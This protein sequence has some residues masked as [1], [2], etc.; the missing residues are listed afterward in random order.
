VGSDLASF[1]FVTSGAT[2][3]G[4]WSF[5]LQVKDNVGVAVNS[6]A[7]SVVV[8]AALVA[9]TVTSSSGAV[10]QG[11]TSILTSSSVTT[12]TSPYTYQ[13]FQMAPGSSAYSAIGGAT[14]TDYSFVTSVSTTTGVWHFKLNVTDATGAVVT[15]LVVSVT[16]NL[17]P[18]VS[19]SPTTVVMGVGQ[20][21]T[22]TATVSGGTSPF[23]YRW[24][25]N[26]TSVLGA[27]NATW[28][29]TPSSEGYYSVYVK[30]TD[31]VSVTA[32]S[33]NS[34]VNVIVAHPVTS[35]GGGI[36]ITGYKLVFEEAMNNSFGSPATIGYYWSFFA[37][38][39]N[40]TQWIAS[41]ISGSTTP[42][43]SYSI[44]ALTLTELPYCA[45]VL[46]MSGP[47]AVAW[48]NWLWINFT[49]H[50]T[51]NSFNYSTN[52]ADE[53]NVHPGDI[54]GAA[55]V[56]PY[57]GADGFCNLLDVTPIALNWLKKVPTGTDPTSGLAIA[58]INGD[59]VVNLKDVTVIALSWLKAWKN[60][61]PQAPKAGKT[62][63][64]THSAVTLKSLS[65]TT[66]IR[67]FLV[68]TRDVETDTASPALSV[69]VSPTAAS[70]TRA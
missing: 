56:F 24:Y 38:K 62:D 21:Q 1:S 23:S 65:Q 30:V 50:W 20:P 60:T 45:Y 10:D 41:G 14:L 34:N 59:G 43:V 15:S 44:A 61:P 69:H 31:V 47:N 66:L 46:P 51:Q 63:S 68:D 5:I 39:W 7:V 32:T 58:D 17:V 16:V 9:P 25:L 6:S 12:G 27:T 33:N 36:G 13:W 53:L 11:Q 64:Q 29:F 22:F 37:D 57:L 67:N 4:S 28:T 52:D 18:S 48:G 8:N 70:I 2:A 55:E 19:I 26:G 3:T 35:I 49:F 54:A 42:V 40:G